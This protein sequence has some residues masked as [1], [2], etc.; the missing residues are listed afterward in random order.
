MRKRII[1]QLLLL[2]PVFSLLS[3]YRTSEL[4]KAFI[5]DGK[6]PKLF[7]EKNASSQDPSFSG[8]SDKVNLTQFD[9]Y[10]SNVVHSYTVVSKTT[11]GTTR[12]GI[13]NL[14]TN[15]VITPVTYKEISLFGRDYFNIN[16]FKD[17]A[18]VFARLTRDSGEKALY[19]ITENKYLVDFDYYETIDY[20]LTSDDGG[21]GNVEVVTTVINE[22]EEVKYF[23]VTF[24]KNGAAE[25]TLK[26][27][28]ESDYIISD[29][30][31]FHDELPKLK[32]YRY[33]MESSKLVGYKAGKK[34]FEVAIATNADTIFYYDKY[35]YTQIST[36]I[37]DDS[38]VYNYSLNGAKYLMETSRVDLTNG[39][40]RN[41]RN[42]DFYFGAN[43]FDLKLDKDDNYAY[44]VA[45]VQKIQ[46][47]VLL[48]NAL[49]LFDANLKPLVNLSQKD[50]SSRFYKV[51]ENLFL[52]DNKQL[53]DENYERV[54]DLRAYWL[55]SRA[56][57]TNLIS[58]RDDDYG[59]ITTKGKIL[60]NFKY[61][62]PFVF[63]N[64]RALNKNVQTDKLEV[65]TT[66]GAVVDELVDDRI[67]I[68]SIQG[69]YTETIDG[70]DT[71]KNYAGLT[72]V[73]ISADEF[74]D[75]V[76]NYYDINTGAKLGTLFAIQNMLD[77][78]TRYVKA[79]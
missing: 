21:A 39:A 10:S 74:L 19:S 61:R 79:Y 38:R 35:L 42:F 67:T 50:Y 49:V 41:Y 7:M 78:T 45:D 75:N 22:V 48:N 31:L 16:T 9:R 60:A 2:V 1:K 4:P 64:E 69:Y 3:C 62:D 65:L 57:N 28:G 56:L 63:Y 18:F 12:Y 6:L 5:L 52:T 76:T 66:S 14:A 47:K 59:L 20:Y 77:F 55:T 26:Q 37:P 43:D 70:V 13:G 71:I 34:V 8:Y 30:K 25:R 44:V 33:V 73:T 53:V 17:V 11:D 54:L 58:L 15:D 27:V 36:Q 72:L 23:N 29:T 46:N 24:D 40:V 68:N 51:G 32:A